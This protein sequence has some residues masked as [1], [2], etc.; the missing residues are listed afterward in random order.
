MA[1]LWPNKEMVAF[2]P[3]LAERSLSCLF[4]SKHFGPQQ[5]GQQVL[6]QAGVFFNL[7]CS[8]N[9]SHNCEK[10]LPSWRITCAVRDFLKKIIK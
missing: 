6:L 10:L 8:T 1:N 5:M 9:F 4:S 7:V 2:G 3:Q